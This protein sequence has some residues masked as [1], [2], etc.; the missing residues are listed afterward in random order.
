MPD[1]F[2]A[3][4]TGFLVSSFVQA[5]V[6]IAQIDIAEGVTTDKDA[7]TPT[8]RKHPLHQHLFRP[9]LPRQFH[10]ISYLCNPKGALVLM[11]SRL[12]FL[13][14]LCW[15]RHSTRERR[16]HSCANIPSQERF[17]ALWTGTVEWRRDSLAPRWKKINSRSRS[18][19]I[20]FRNLRLD[21]AYNCRGKFT[22]NGNKK[23]TSRGD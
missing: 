9:R 14:E 19:W 15:C 12:Q 7:I 16:L 10:Q 11:F 23:K 21:L 8:L 22:L 6:G 13:L 2:F 20:K 18:L 5:R 1:W 3:S 4:P 17:K